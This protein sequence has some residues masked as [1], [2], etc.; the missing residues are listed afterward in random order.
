VYGNFFV[1][2]L[3]NNEDSSLIF[4]DEVGFCVAHRTKRGRSIIGS[5]VIVETA[6]IR[7]RKISVIA[8]MNKF[9]M[10]DF[11][12]NFSP[13]NGIDFGEYITRLNNLLIIKGIENPVF[14]MDNARIHH[15]RI[16][17]GYFTEN[18]NAQIVYLPPY[19]PFLNPIENCF[20]KWKN[21]VLRAVANNEL[22]L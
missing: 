3:I 10:V 14:I 21:H 11:H 8:A 15:S 6:N 13:V 5:S 17:K 19:S 2:L 7:S 1:E 12:V 20:S 22:S 16:A 4:I 18:L 9:G